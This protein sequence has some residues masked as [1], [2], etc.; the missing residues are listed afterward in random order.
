MNQTPQQLHIPVLL[1]DVLDLLKPQL[2]ESYLDLTAGYGGHARAV[3]ARIGG[4][5]SA[6]LTDKV[7]LVDRDDFAIE[8]LN[9]L[10]EQG[11]RI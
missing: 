3:I 6:S 8:H 10:K 7:T 2:G 5:N 9:D 11:A 4:E 1:S